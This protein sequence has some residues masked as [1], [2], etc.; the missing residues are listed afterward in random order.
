MGPRAAIGRI[1]SGASRAHILYL[2]GPE[3]LTPPA[4]EVLRAWFGHS[5][6]VELLRQPEDVA[7]VVRTFQRAARSPHDEVEVIV[8]ET[9]AALTAE[10]ALLRS[11]WP[12]ARWVSPRLAMAPSAPPRQPVLTA[13]AEAFAAEVQ[14]AIQEYR[15]QQ[16]DELNAALAHMELLRGLPPDRLSW[17]AERVELRRYE[18]G[19]TIVRVGDPGDGV[20][21]IHSGEVNILDDGAVGSERVIARRGR[22]E[23]FGDLALITGEPRANTVV[24][25]LDSE[26]FFLSKE[27]HDEL[28]VAV[29]ALGAHLRRV[30]SARLARAHRRPRA[31]P[32]IIAHYRA[33]PNDAEGRTTRALAEAITAETKRAVLLLEL[34]AADPSLGVDSL[35]RVIAQLQGSGALSRGDCVETG[36]GLWRLAAR[37]AETLRYLQPPQ[38]I[39]LLL[40]GLT[41]AF[42]FVL[43]GIGGHTPTDVVV[44]MVKQC[45]VL[46]LHVA[47]GADHGRQAADLVSLVHRE[48]PSARSKITI[49]TDAPAHSAAADH[50]RDVLG[51]RVDH[52][53]PLDPGAALAA[54]S[55]SLTVR[56]LLGIAVGLALG[57]G[58]ARGAAHLGVLDVLAE[59]GI[60]IDMIGGTSA[61]AMVGGYAAMGRSLADAVEC[62]RRE[63]VVSPIH[64]YTLSKSALFSDRALEGILRRLYGDR[65]IEE[66]PIPFFAVATDLKRALATPIDR[67]PLWLAVRAS[68]SLPGAIAPVRLGDT[69]FVDGGVADNVPAD[70]LRDRGA[71]FV[72]AV[73]ISRERMFNE[74]RVLPAP[75]GHGLRR[76]RWLREF[77]DSPSMLHVVARAME[78][79]SAQTVKARAWSWNVCIRPDV[80]DFGLFEVGTTD[81]LMALGREA[82]AKSLSDIKAGLRAMLD[83][84]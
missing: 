5:H 83:E 13:E 45:D 9:P 73:D 34:A 20:Y 44:R 10:A 11:H 84:L 51:L 71:R 24:A 81:P 46:L 32:R 75:G 41:E 50:L 74:R 31:T 82:A 70:L 2:S 63:T 23:H 21:F 25:D 78:V 55:Y 52:R 33:A 56:R 68:C 61:G 72:I 8:V 36:L 53:L 7:A 30:L 27:Y 42:D 19:E 37:R 54:R 48:C 65:C 15:R 80:G 22:G 29:P 43:V 38:I 39:P 4:M 76:I 49:A 35:E 66:L 16:W 40:G 26:I 69:Y 60:P 64:R 1:A 79:Q 3:P 57:G 18:A 58:G 6:G 47:P 67:G 17:M 59:A 12:A 28:M 14:A 62:W 77:L